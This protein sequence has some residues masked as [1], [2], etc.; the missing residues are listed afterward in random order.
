MRSVIDRNVFMR[1]MTVVLESLLRPYFQGGGPSFRSRGFS[2]RNLCSVEVVMKVQKELLA[3]FKSLWCY[4]KNFITRLVWETYFWE[5]T[6]CKILPPQG[7]RLILPTTLWR[8]Q[9]SSF[10]CD[11]NEICTLLRFYAA[12]SGSFLLTF[13]DDLSNPTFKGQPAF[14]FYYL[15]LE[16]RTDRLSRNVAKNLPT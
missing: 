4:F 12:K 14:F 16:N 9:I 3:V 11:V 6:Y 8:L 7:A 13:R 2:Y 10:L 5:R 15:T 1:S